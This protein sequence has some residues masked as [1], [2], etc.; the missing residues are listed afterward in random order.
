MHRPEKSD[1]LQNDQHAENRT[2]KMQNNGRKNGLQNPGMQTHA[3]KRA[4][5]ICVACVCS[6]WVLRSVLP[7]IVLHLW[8]A[9]FPVVRGELPQRL[10]SG[11]LLFLTLR[12]LPGAFREHSWGIPGRFAD[13]RG[14][15]G[16]I[17][18]PVKSTLPGPREGS[19]ISNVHLVVV[20]AAV[21]L[22][23]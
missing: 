9:F 3:K 6:F 23:V 2:P 5:R 20:A 12:E 21:R 11:P 7:A 10:G 17:L 1:Q 4:K 22:R 8:G 15:R 19:S 16:N 18:R 14:L 13:T